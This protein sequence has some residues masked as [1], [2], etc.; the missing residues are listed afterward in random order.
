MKVWPAWMS[1][2]RQAGGRDITAWVE[3]LLARA[4]RRMTTCAW[5]LNVSAVRLGISPDKFW[6]YMASSISVSVVV[7]GMS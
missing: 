4:V 7:L 6:A 5:L 2:V 1:R 3:L